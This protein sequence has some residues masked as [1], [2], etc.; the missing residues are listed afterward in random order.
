MAGGPCDKHESSL[1]SKNY[2]HMEWTAERISRFWDWQAQ[3]PDVYF[4]YQFG[5]AIVGFLKGYLG[6]SRRVLDYG[7]GV[8]YLLPHLCACVPEV[9]GA[10]PSKESV[11]RT[12]DRLVETPSFKGAFL[13][14]ELRARRLVFDAVLCV[15]VVEHLDDAAL[16]TVFTDIRSLL[17]PGGVAV[18][19]TPNNEDLSKS[20]IISPATGE[21]FHRWQHLRSWDHNTLPASLR[22]AGFDVVEV[23]ETNMATSKSNTPIGFL[24]RALKRLVFGDPGRPHLICVA[25]IATRG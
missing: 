6:R 8:G 12:N 15:E 2:P 18:F 20:M 17:A 9:Y 24:R 21:I 22:A 1:M 5:P 14:E 25:K 23:V 7:C 13:I 3:Y 11:A 19:S 4:T 10:D 16:A